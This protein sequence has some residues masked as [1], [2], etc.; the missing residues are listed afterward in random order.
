MQFLLQQRALHH[1]NCLIAAAVA[2]AAAALCTGREGIVRVRRCRCVG[3]SAQSGRA[4][5][6]GFRV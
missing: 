1:I 3:P 4:V 6:L 2:A 5:S